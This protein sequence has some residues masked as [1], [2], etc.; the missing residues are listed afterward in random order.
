MIF[1]L[2][3]VSINL[4]AP[5]SAVDA[6]SFTFSLNCKNYRNSLRHEGRYLLRSNLSGHPP[7]TLWRYYMQLCQVEEAFKNLKGDLSIRPVYHQHDNRIKAH[8]FI[9]FLAYCLHVTLRLRLQQS[10][11]GLTPRSVLEKMASI[12]MLDIHLP[13]TDGRELKMS[14]HTQPLAEHQLILDK[15]NLQLPKQPKPRIYSKL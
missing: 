14:R 4:P 9:A 1:E 8:I 7:A 3:N 5:G 11:P 13:T 10:A 15:L 2:Q 6:R 12:Q